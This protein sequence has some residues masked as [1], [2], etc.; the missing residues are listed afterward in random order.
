MTMKKLFGFTIVILF[1]IM[2]FASG[3]IDS[4]EQGVTV[5][6]ET[7]G[8]GESTVEPITGDNE[9]TE[10]VDTEEECDDYDPCTKDVFD[11]D[12]GE[13]KHITISTCCGDGKCSTT[14][15]CNEELHQTK[16]V[17][18]CGRTCPEFLIVQK[19]KSDNE[20]DV[21]AMSCG[22]ANCEQIDENRFLISTSSGNE[23]TI[24]TYVVNLGE[25]TSSRAF[26]NFVCWS[27]EREATQD[28]HKINGIFISDYF[29]SN[30]KKVEEVITINPV[31]AVNDTN[32]AI[33]YMS[34]DP[35]EFTEP[36][37]SHCR[38]FIRTI[39]SV[40]EQAFT[41]SFKE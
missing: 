9:S 22:D 38:V 21:F 30:G 5:P 29:E 20:G 7:A 27:G 13:C 8:S 31:Q 19:D 2:I 24:K 35:A 23:S 15:R 12:T 34:F 28:K 14:E 10:T 39:G 4:S 36:F 37:V 1:V 26:S 17:E 32:H 6:V 25:K 41:V 40:N 16:C 33:Y 3:C 11:A 18:D